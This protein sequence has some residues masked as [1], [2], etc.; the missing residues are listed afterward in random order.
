VIVLKTILKIIVKIIVKIIAGSVHL[1]N[2]NKLINKQ[3]IWKTSK[4]C[5]RCQPT[6][7]ITN[8]NYQQITKVTTN[9]N[10]IKIN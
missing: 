10:K 9:N 7:V 8:K 3:F 4:S 1:N 5:N 6:R 2:N